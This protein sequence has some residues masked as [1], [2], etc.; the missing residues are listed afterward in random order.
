MVRIGFH[1]LADLIPPQQVLDESVLAAESGFEGIFIPDH[2]HPWTVAPGT[3]FAWTLI[4][5]VAERTNNTPIGTAVTCPTLRYNPAIVAQAFATLGAVYEGR[6]FLGLGTGEALNEVP[7]GN[8]WPG[9]G[10]RLARLREAIEVIRLLWTGQ[11]V[12]HAG[13]YYRLTDAKLYT[14]PRKPV[15]IY[16]SGFGP[17]AAELAGSKGD[18]WITGTLPES[19][20]KDVLFPAFENGVR[21][22]GRN[23]DGVEK[24]VE[25]LISYDE[26]WDKA[27]ESCRQIAG[28][29][30]PEVQQN[31]VHDPRVIK[32]YADKVPRE[33]IAEML[34]VY[35]HPDNIVSKVES[36]AKLGFTWIEVASLSPDNRVFLEVFREK[37]LPYVK[38]NNRI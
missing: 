14:L 33:K 11:H 18:G 8:N 9:R 22:S 32:A 34:P 19:L 16:I 2:F 13:K 23:H 20:Y 6:T 15:P 30:V 38:E 28:A 3:P 27:V 21:S 26:D 29:M 24:I 37:V 36:L 35:D 12:T 1:P 25:L 10:E 31:D 4:A 7:T 5:S 17:R